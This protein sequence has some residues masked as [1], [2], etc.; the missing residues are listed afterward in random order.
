MDLAKKGIKIVS[1]ER[2]EKAEQER[3]H[4][5]GLQGKRLS[6]KRGRGTE[7]R[8]CSQGTSLGNGK[9]TFRYAAWA[10]ILRGGDKAKNKD[11]TGIE[12]T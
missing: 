3:P 12:E 6:T 11:Y 4:P 5:G 9:N 2:T 8:G 10:R 7:R 1:S